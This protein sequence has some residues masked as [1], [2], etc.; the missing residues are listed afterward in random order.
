MIIQMKFSSL[1]IYKRTGLAAQ[2]PIITPARG[3]TRQ[4]ITKTE[5][6]NT[7]RTNQKIKTAERKEYKRS[8]GTNPL[9]PGKHRQVV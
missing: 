9:N 7:K 8:T 5:K 1:C 2:T 6:Q 4:N 3:N